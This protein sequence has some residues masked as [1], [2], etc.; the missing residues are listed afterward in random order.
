[1]GRDSGDR[2]FEATMNARQ[3]WQAVLGDLQLQVAPA[4]FDTW[5]KATAIVGASDGRLLVGAPNTFA[6]EQLR[7]RFTSLIQRAL[8][9]ILGYEVTV[10]F[11][12]YGEAELSASPPPPRPLERIVED[13]LPRQLTLES[14]P[15]HGLNPDYTFATFIVG[16]SNQFAHAASQ[17]VG[18]R[19]GQKFNPLF[20]HGDVGL[21]KTHLIHAAGHRA[22]ELFS[23]FNVLYVSSEKFMNELILAIRQQRTDEFRSRYRTIDMLLIDDIQFIAGTDSTQEEF[24]HTFNELYQTGRQVIITSDRHPRHLPTL[25]DRLRSRFEGGL[26]AEVEAP[27]SETRIAFLRDRA[28]RLAMPFPHAVIDFLA[29][30]YQSNFRELAGA[31]NRIVHRAELESSAITLSLATQA[32]DDAPA[33]ARRRLVTP[34]RV[35]RL[36]ADYFRVD[37]V[38]L[39]GKSR[40]KEIVLPRQVAMYILRQESETSLNDIGLA[41]GGR[42]HTTVMYGVDTIRQRI[43]TDAHLRQ[44]VLA[45]RDQLYAAE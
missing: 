29:Q 12:V 30:R 6:V 22:L 8:A 16:K 13:R 45:L 14:T 36:V 38:E 15:L 35:I 39:G 11:T 41:L 21:G 17:S 23:G 1:M 2:S 26:I 20:I 5:L 25:A 43:E 24:F 32:L 18:E 7:S 42:D 44:Q 34:E 3:V 33:T 37:Q 28:E 31:F 40:R 9:T 4:V 10:E 19:P 27:D